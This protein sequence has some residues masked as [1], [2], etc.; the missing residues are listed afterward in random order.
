MQLLGKNSGWAYVQL[1]TCTREGDENGLAPQPP[2]RWCTSRIS[3]FEV[4]GKLRLQGDQAMLVGTGRV[5]QKMLWLLAF[6]LER[7][8]NS[9]S[10]GSTRLI[11]GFGL[12]APRTA[13]MK[14][15]SGL[16]S[17]LPPLLPFQSQQY[18]FLFSPQLFFKKSGSS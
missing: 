18:Y 1:D 16:L 2:C 6:S 14:W 11:A 12:I 7:P 10:M 13:G 3:G 4:A 8:R 9:D 15:F 5:L 17:S